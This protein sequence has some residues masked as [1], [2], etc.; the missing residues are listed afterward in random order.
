MNSRK[1]NIYIYFLN[2]KQK[3]KERKKQ[4]LEK[5]ERRDINFFLKSQKGR[6]KRQNIIYKINKRYDIIPSFFFT[7]QNT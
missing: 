5:K 3:S 1:K 2:A 7:F 4:A 6:Q